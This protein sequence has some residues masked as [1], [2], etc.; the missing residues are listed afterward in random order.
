MAVYARLYSI[1]VDKSGGDHYIEQNIAE[2]LKM[3]KRDRYSDYRDIIYYM[4]AQMEL[5]RN[6]TG[7]AQQL[8]IKA[9]QYSN[10]NIS[11]RNR[12]YMKLADLAFANKDYR[13]A[14]NF[15]DSLILSDPEIKDVDVINKKKEMLG[16]LALQT[17]I[18]DRQDSLQRIAAMPDDQRKDFVKKIL[19]EMRKQ[20][21]LKEGETLIT[22][23][24]GFAPAYD[25][26]SSSQS[27]KGE[28]Y[29]YNTVLKTRGASEFKSRWGNRPNVDNW[30]RIQAVTNQGNVRAGYNANNP[31]P[32]DSSLKNNAPQELTFDNLY[33]NL[34]LTEA[35]LKNSNDSI[36]DALFALGKIYAEDL[37]DCDAVI[38]TYEQLRNRYP[39]FAKMDEVLF[40]LYYCYNKNGDVSTAGELKSE[41]NAKYPSS[42]LTTIITTG[43]DPKKEKSED[44]TKTYEN[45][46]D[47]FIEGNF[48]QAVAQKKVADSLFGE[49]YWTPQLLYIESVYYVRQREDSTAISELKKIQAKYPGSPLAE[50]ATTL[51]DVLGRRKQIEEEL[52]N[53][54]I[55]RPQPEVRNQP[56]A[57]TTA[58]K[59]MIV[60]TD[61]SVIRKP[62]TNPIKV[63]SVT[64]KK[65]APIT[66]FSFN[67]QAPHYVMII[68]NKVDVV[69]GNETKNAFAR[70]NTEKFYNKTFELSILNLDADTKLVLIKPFDNAQAAI[71]YI[72]GVRPKAASEIIPWLKADKY[73]FS[74][75]TDQNLEILKSNPDLTSYRLFLD[76]NLPGK[77]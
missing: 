68:L 14:Y 20:A 5:E 33:A 8:L 73:S 47:L 19:K 28:W 26:F 25:L 10:G 13:H 77:L 69:F 16:K 71:D 39:G 18:V 43:K 59:P 48:D 23:G 17:E 51:I 22:A 35:Q 38:R 27:S 61:T 65:A 9:A 74:I 56:V 11:Q 30:R 53:L 67:P 24:S 4:A 76:Q 45:I 32:S 60:K 42:K 57:D 58:S 55:E 2:L 66:S 6:N 31:N 15:Y 12:I 21:G 3:A 34:P 49:N 52:T 50:K 70:Y 36:Q 40:H 64:K 63:D 1:K 41:M 37:E 7:G 75:I 54:Q 46:Y 29:F 72:N 44:A 62:I